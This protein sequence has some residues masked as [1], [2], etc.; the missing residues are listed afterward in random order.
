MDS[1]NFHD[2][3]S[4]EQLFKDHIEG[5]KK[6][7]W[8]RNARICFFGE[9]NVGHEIGH[10]QHVLANYDNTWT[11]KQNP[12]RDFGIWTD[13]EAKLSYAFAAQLEFAKGNVY[14]LE[15]LVCTNAFLAPATRTE[16]T[17]KE[18]ESQA[19]RYKLISSNPKTPHSRASLAVSGKVGKNGKLNAGFND[20]LFFAFTGAV[21]VHDKILRRQ[22]EN[23]NYDFFD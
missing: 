19:A 2:V 13:Q 18:F 17:I 22:L 8:T 5:L 11:Y 12:E 21:G 15:N 1:H 6:H 10:M 16:D 20:D 4:Q 3:A 9:R 14:Y 7:V 23:V